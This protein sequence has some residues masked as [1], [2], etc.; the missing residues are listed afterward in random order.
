MKKDRMLRQFS[1]VVNQMM[2]DMQQRDDE[3]GVVG[4]AF[5]D[6]QKRAF[7][8]SSREGDISDLAYTGNVGEAFLT[9]SRREALQVMMSLGSRPVKFVPVIRHVLFGLT[10]QPGALDTDGDDAASD[11]PFP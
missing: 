11:I 1:Q 8:S 9:G 4:Y 2:D 6:T 3:Q 10:P 5:F 7:L